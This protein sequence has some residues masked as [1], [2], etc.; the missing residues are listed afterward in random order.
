MKKII[1]VF[2]LVIL[3]SLTLSLNAQ[4]VKLEVDNIDNGGIV[5]GKTYRIYAVYETAGDIIDAVYAKKGF[6]IMIHST[7][8]FYQHP[9]GGALSRDIQRSDLAMYPELAF[10]SW[11][12]IALED[13]Y[14]NEMLSVTIDFQTFEQGGSLQSNNGA[15]YAFPG[16]S[17]GGA[18]QTISGASKRILLMQL[19]TEGDVK[20][21]INIHGRHKENFDKDGALI[22][23]TIEIDASA[24]TFECQ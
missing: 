24:L 2:N 13:N 8:P 1:C 4:F 21:L 3:F 14:V 12:T 7:K 11:V 9:R 19:T 6:P 18:R 23:P 22:P 20:G 15:W 10:D 5:P 16:A 17:K